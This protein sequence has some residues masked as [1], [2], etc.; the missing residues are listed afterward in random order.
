MKQGKVSENVWKRSIKKEIK[1]SRYPVVTGVVPGG[2]CALL[3]ISEE[4]EMAVTTDTYVCQGQDCGIYGVHKAINN[5]VSS[6]ADPVAITVAVL[7]PEEEKEETLQKL[8]QTMAETCEQLNVQ[9]IGGDTRITDGVNRPLV[10]VTGLGRVKK[11]CRM[12]AGDARPG[13]DIV[14]TKWIGLEG[15]AILARER[16]D[17][18]KK[19]LPCTYIDKAC[20]FQEYLSV[21]PEARLARRHGAVF[22]HDVSEGGIFGALWEMAQAAKTGLEI[23]LR[24]IPVRQE[25]V[26]LC[27]CL[28]LNPYQLIS[29]GALLIACENGQ[30]MVKLLENHQIPAS[31]I[32]KM[33]KG[34][35]R[36]IINQEDVR[37]MDLPKSDEIYKR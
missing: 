26:E 28:R 30:N 21:M 19:T 31:V 34:N 22:M 17:L 33:T 25:T 9:I 4:E 3:E 37:Y 23:D 2:D 7:L 36:I 24:K 20:T 16:Q 12:S 18:L 8:M 35:D 14:V 6:G 32:G 15:T 27:E 11:E 5:L 13:M 29:G 1:K 10:T